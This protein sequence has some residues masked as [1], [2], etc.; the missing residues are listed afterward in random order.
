MFRVK[1]KEG[2][3]P[4]NLL[5]NL[6]SISSSPLHDA[7]KRGNIDLLKECLDNKEGTKEINKTEPARVEHWA[8]GNIFLMKNERIII[9][10]SFP[11]RFL[12]TRLILLVILPS[13]GLRG[14]GH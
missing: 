7:A 14:R 11:P 2:L 9:F 4:S 10:I 8:L 3:V 13:T 1:G 5:E 6:S 12:S